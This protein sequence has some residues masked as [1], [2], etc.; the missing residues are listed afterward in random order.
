[1]FGLSFWKWLAV[2]AAITNMQVINC[3]GRATCY[4]WLAGLKNM[5]ACMDSLFTAGSAGELRV[6]VDVFR[7]SPGATRMF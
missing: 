6:E 7:Q 2:L 3:I 5:A 4:R 1:M